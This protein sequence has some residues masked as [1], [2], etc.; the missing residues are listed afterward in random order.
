MKNK[1][2]KPKLKHTLFFFTMG[3]IASG[4]MLVLMSAQWFS[5]LPGRVSEL[6]TGPK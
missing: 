6:I 1:K 5:E 4:G 2:F 3:V